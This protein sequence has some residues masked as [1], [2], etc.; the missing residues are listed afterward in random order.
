MAS[1]R[2]RKLRLMSEDPHCHWCGRLVVDNCV[3]VLPP[4]HTLLDEEGTLDHLISRHQGR[5]S[6]GIDGTILSCF[7]CNQL[8]GQIEDYRSYGGDTSQLEIVWAA[9]RLSQIGLDNHPTSV[10][11]SK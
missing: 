2:K 10:K 1:P 11:V 8:R 4:G 6:G 9:Y 3:T 5:T 7:R